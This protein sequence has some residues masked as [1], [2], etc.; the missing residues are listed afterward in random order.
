MNINRVILTGNLTRD[1]EMR[2][3]PGGVSICKF[4]IAVSSGTTALHLAVA[5]LEFS[6]GDEILVSASTNIATALAVYHNN[7]IPIPVDSESRTFAPRGTRP[8]GETFESRGLTRVEP[9][10]GQAGGA[11]SLSSGSSKRLPH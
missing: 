3:T 1:P 7:L 2:G 6:R 5:A 11:A 4:G 10:L 9:Q 8:G